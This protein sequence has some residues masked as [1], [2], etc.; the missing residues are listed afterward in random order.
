[1]NL[2]KKGLEQ[3]G[4]LGWSIRTGNSKFIN[5]EGNTVDKCS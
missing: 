1:M 2:M 4:Y 3:T 5:F